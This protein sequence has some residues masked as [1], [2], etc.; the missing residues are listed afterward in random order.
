MRKELKFLLLANLALIVFILEYTFDLFML[1]TDD[2]S[3]EAIPY[4]DIATNHIPQGQMI[5]PKII[6]QTYKTEDIPKHWVHGQQRC[7]DLH[8]DY[9]YIL[10]TDEMS[11]DFIRENFSWFLPTFE[12][13]KFPIQRADAIRYFVL[14]T[15][16]GVYID[17]DDVCE[18]PLDPLLK[19]PVF[20]RKTSP[21]GVSNDV[22]GTI[23]HHPFFLKAINSLNHYNKNWFAPYFT[24]MGSTGPVFISV[25]WKQYKRWHKIKYDNVTSY[26]HS[27]ESV[28]VLQPDDYKTSAHAFFSIS[29]GSSWH[30]DDADFIKSFQTHILSCVVAGF[31]FGFFILYFEYSVYCLL[32]AKK[33]IINSWQQAWQELV[34]R[35]SRWRQQDLSTTASYDRG[36]GHSLKNFQRRLRKDSNNLLRLHILDLEKN[37]A[38]PKPEHDTTPT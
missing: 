26:V 13:Y 37:G 24:I 19:Y 9:E 11:H 28:R 35:V 8:P 5:I 4:A 12:N 33:N 15:Y 3:E 14:L 29:K 7:K 31:I 18:R 21:L 27:N 1:I 36:A 10:W 22:M 6:H 20:V 25:V 34:K 23:P 2:T 38:S 30:L 17:L 32:C 16:G